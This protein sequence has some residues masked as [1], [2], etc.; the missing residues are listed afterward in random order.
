MNKGSGSGSGIFPEPDPDPGDQDPTGSGSGSA[1][2]DFIKDI[3]LAQKS[4]ESPTLDAIL[5]L[6]KSLIK[7]PDPIF[8]F[9]KGNMIFK[10][11]YQN[12]YVYV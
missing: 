10:S 12:T 7:Y 1:T 4:K 2:L 5:Y 11:N 3:C 9:L 8:S 6:S